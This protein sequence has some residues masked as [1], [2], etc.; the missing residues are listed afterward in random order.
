MK[1]MLRPLLPWSAKF[2]NNYTYIL[3]ALS[4]DKGQGVERE[5]ESLCAFVCVCVCACGVH[6]PPSPPHRTV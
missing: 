5:R 1:T 2:N 6:A 3:D 4:V